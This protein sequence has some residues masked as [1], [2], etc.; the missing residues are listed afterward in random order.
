MIERA[1]LDVVIAANRAC[2]KRA[3]ELNTRCGENLFKVYSQAELQA[4]LMERL[5]GARSISEIQNLEALYLP[6]LDGEMVHLVLAENPENIQVLG[7]EVAV[8]YRGVGYAPR[9]TIKNILEGNRWQQLPDDGVKLPGGRVVELVFTHSYNT[10]ASGKDVPALKTKVQEYLNA[11]QWNSW[12]KPTMAL[13]DHGK[14]TE[15]P[16]LLEM[17]YGTCVI[18]RNALMGYGTFVLKSYRSYSSDPWFEPRWYRSKKEAET[19]H[20]IA[21]A[22]FVEIEGKAREARNLEEAKKAAQAAQKKVSDMYDT[23][24]HNRDLESAL[25]Q[26]IYSRRYAYLPST[27]AELEK[28]QAD[29]EQFVVRVEAAVIEVERKKEEERKVAERLGQLLEKEYAACPMCDQPWYAQDGSTCYCIESQQFDDADEQVIFRESTATDGRVLVQAKLYRQGRRQEQV[30]LLNVVD[31]KVPEL[32]EVT[33]QTLWTPPSEE[34]RELRNKLQN[35][36]YRLQD[37]DRELDKCEGDYPS[38]VLVK[39]ET[40]GER[41]TLFAIANVREL[42]VQELR[43]GDYTPVSGSVRFVCDPKRCQWLDLPPA[44]GQTWVCS[45]GKMISR[46]R[47]GRPV[48]GANPQMRVDGAR[49][50]IEAEIETIKDE[51]AALHGKAHAEDVTE[52]MSVGAGDQSEDSAVTACAVTQ[53]MFAALKARFGR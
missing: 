12:A 4:F 21:A 45:F 5:A 40:D 43:S 17:Q 24:Y 44:N 19:A 33:T 34:E 16:A 23:Y 39:F 37:L 36:E 31:H 53:D 29:A 14:D 50:A 1:Q 47:K 13:P 3:R 10:I 46:D 18:T 28:W 30:V 38:R 8:E 15:F 25:R 7:E 49:G 22:K 42:S 2:Q 26:E 32:S 27:V 20:A 35:V 51:I 11:Q 9:V 41:G 48:I 6:E 52:L